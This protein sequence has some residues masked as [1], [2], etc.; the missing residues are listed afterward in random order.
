MFSFAEENPVALT[1]LLPQGR[2]EGAGDA[3]LHHCRFVICLLLAFL[4]S[5]SGVTAEN[6]ATSVRS[7]SRLVAFPER[8][9]LNNRSES[10]DVI[11]QWQLPDGSTQDVSDVARKEISATNVARL[12]E[13]FVVPV[14]NGK[15]ELRIEYEGTVCTIPIEVVHFELPTELR[16]RNDVLP[17]LTR[18]GCNTGSVTVPHPVRTDFDSACSDTTRRATTT[19]SHAK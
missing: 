2:G 5:Q 7:E 4:V 8:I 17:V 19:E 3:C 18:A 15:T 16:F 10:Q 11:V 9:S 12:N 6:E 13:G 14:S 1:T